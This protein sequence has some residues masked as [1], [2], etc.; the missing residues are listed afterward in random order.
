[1]TA[2]SLRTCCNSCPANLCRT[3]TDRLVFFS[4]EFY[5]RYHTPSD[6]A[7]PLANRQ[8]SV[9]VVGLYGDCCWV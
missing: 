8:L 5:T 7:Y 9:G 2:W 3:D 4:G 1:M 6:A